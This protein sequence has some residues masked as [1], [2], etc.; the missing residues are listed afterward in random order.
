[1][2]KMKVEIYREVLRDVSANFEGAEKFINERIPEVFM[3]LCS[4]V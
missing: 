3:C 1:M 2:N 4:S